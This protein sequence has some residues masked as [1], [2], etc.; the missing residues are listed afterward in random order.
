MGSVLK[1]MHET[2]KMYS[3]K[4]M[5]VILDKSVSQKHKCKAMSNKQ[6]S[7]DKLG[8]V[9]HHMTSHLLHESIDY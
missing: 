1:G 6:K 3:F 8:S 7:C 2:H 5:L 4:S 9:P